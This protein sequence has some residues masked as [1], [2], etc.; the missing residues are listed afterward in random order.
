MKPTY[1][2]HFT[3]AKQPTAEVV[4]E[5]GAAALRGIVFIKA[6]ALIQNLKFEP[7]P[8]CLVEAIFGGTN[9]APLKQQ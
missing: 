8:A 5:T 1:C 2:G 3:L 7:V 9:F 6:K 4:F